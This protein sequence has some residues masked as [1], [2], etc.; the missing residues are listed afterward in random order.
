MAGHSKGV[1]VGNFCALRRKKCPHN[2]YQKNCTPSP[3]GWAT[4]SFKQG[5]IKIE[6][7]KHEAHHLLCVSCVTEF[8]GYDEQIQ[9]IV[10]QTP[11]CINSTTNMFAMPLWGHTIKYY[12]NLRRSGATFR[13]R[14]ADPP[15]FE[16]IPQHD[17]DHNSDNGYTD[18]VGKDL[19]KVARQIAKKRKAHEAAIMELESRLNSLSEKYRKKL[20]GRGRRCQGTHYAWTVAGLSGD[21]KWCHPFSMA[22]KPEK[23]TFPTT[24][25]VLADKIAELVAVLGR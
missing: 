21:A 11:W 14:S 8:I 23:R 17:Y 13:D 1:D 2:E 5:Q 22:A 24:S 6:N 10:A 3:V 25:G 20:Q 16:N 4:Y 15:K 9:E 19:E 7:K 12:C 18:E